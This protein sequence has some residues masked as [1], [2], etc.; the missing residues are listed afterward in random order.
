MMT[1]NHWRV[2]DRYLK[3]LQSSCPGLT[4]QQ[5]RDLIRVQASQLNSPRISD[6]EVNDFL[7]SH[8]L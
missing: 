2:L 1:S 5:L 4:K 7:R 6:A 8:G 3:N